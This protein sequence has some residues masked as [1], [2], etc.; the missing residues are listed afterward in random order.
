M[1]GRAAAAHWLKIFWTTPRPREIRDRVI[2]LMREA[3]I[4]VTRENYITTN[5]GEPVPEWTVG[6]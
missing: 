1:A 2:A 6:A 3:G 4:P 5:W